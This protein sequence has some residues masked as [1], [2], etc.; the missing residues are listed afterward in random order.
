ME[1]CIKPVYFMKSE[2]DAKVCG[3]I[4]GLQRS[5]ISSL[6]IVIILLF[7]QRKYLNLSVYHFI[8]LL[9]VTLIVVNLILIV[10]YIIDYRNKY[11]GMKDMYNEMI[12]DG[13]DKYKAYS[14]I[15]SMTTQQ[16]SSLPPY[17]IASLGSLIVAS[18]QKNKEEEK[19]NK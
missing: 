13:M 9:T 6:I 15:Q 1:Q 14:T 3:L 4:E 12:K 17:A 5:L 7:L 16:S 19:E 18:K 8:I 2:D 10:Y 11:I